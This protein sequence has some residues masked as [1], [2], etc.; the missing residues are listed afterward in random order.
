MKSIVDSIEKVGYYVYNPVKTSQIEGIQFCMLSE[1]EKIKISEVNIIHKEKF[2]NGQPIP[3]GLFDPNMGTVSR[4]YDCS[5]CGLDYVECVGHFGLLD[6]GTYIYKFAYLDRVKTILDLFC[7]NCSRI[8]INEEIINKTMKITVMKDRLRYIKEIFSSSSSS[9]HC[10]H[11]GFLQPVIAVKP[12]GKITYS[13]RL[14][15]SKE[16]SSIKNPLTAE[17]VYEKF[18]RISD[19]DLKILG[20]NPKFSRPENL[21]IRYMLV[22]PPCLRCPLG[23]EKY[24]KPDDLDKLISNVVESASTMR[25][26]RGTTRRIDDIIFDIAQAYNT[27]ILGGAKGGLTDIQGAKSILERIGKKGGII[28][29]NLTGKRVEFAGRTVITGL[30]SL[31]ISEAS[32][33]LRIAMGLTIEERTTKYNIEY[34]QGLVDNGASIYPGA[35]F[36]ERAG[37]MINLKIVKIP[38]ILEI[39]DIVHRHMIEGDPFI[40]NRYPSLHEHS[41]MCFSGKISPISETISINLLITPPFNADFDGDEM[42]VHVAKSVQT[43]IEAHLLANVKKQVMRPATGANYGGFIFDALLGCYRITKYP[44]TLKKELIMNAV[45]QCTVLP[46]FDKIKDMCGTDFISMLLPPISLKKGGVE[47]KLGKITKGGIISKNVMKGDGFNNIPYRIHMDISG[48]LMVDTLYNLQSS[49]DIILMSIG[50]TVSIKDLII[51]DEKTTKR[52]SDILEQAYIEVAEI[53]KKIA[54]NSLIIPQEIIPIN[55]VSALVASHMENGF[56]KIAA[57]IEEKPMDGNRFL[58]MV[59]SGA[60]GK[61]M[62]VICMAFVIGYKSF[63]GNNLKRAYGDRFLP[64]FTRYTLDP[65]NWGFISSSFLDGMDP[66]EFFTFGVAGREGLIDTALGTAEAGYLNRKLNAILGGDYVEYDMTVR[67][68]FGIVIQMLFGGCGFD[69]KYILAYKLDICYKTVTEIKKEYFLSLGEED[70]KKKGEEDNKKKGEEDKKKKGEEDKKKKGE[71]EEEDKKKDKKKKGGKKEKKKKGEKEEEKRTKKEEKKTKKEIL[72][73]EQYKLLSLRDKVCSSYINKRSMKINGGDRIMVYSPFNIKSIVGYCLDNYE[74]LNIKPIPISVERWYWNIMRVVETI[75]KYY[76]NI[77][78]E[79]Q[80]EIYENSVIPLRLYILSELSTKKVI[81]EYKLDEAG[82]RWILDMILFNFQRGLIEPNKNVGCSTSQCISMNSTQMTLNTFHF[83]GIASMSE[84]RTKGI[85]R[86]REILQLTAPKKQKTPSMAIY[87][88]PEYATFRSSAQEVAT[89]IKHLSIID[90]LQSSGIYYEYIPMKKFAIKSDSVWVKEFVKYNV[91]E[92]ATNLSSW[93]IRF[94]FSRIKLY[95]ERL[96]LYEISFAL[97]KAFGRMVYVVSSSDSDETPTIIM[98]FVKDKIPSNKEEFGYV[99]ETLQK[100][101]KKGVH[102]RGISG[103]EESHVPPKPTD[104]LR[105]DIVTQDLVIGEDGKAGVKEWGVGAQ[106][107]NLS[108]ILYESI[109]YI[110]KKKIVSNSAP[111]VYNILGIEASRRILIE[112]IATIFGDDELH[113]HHIELVADNMT[114]LGFLISINRFGILKGNYGELSKIAFEQ[115]VQN[116]KDACFIGK[117]DEMRGLEA[118]IVTGQLIPTGTGTKIGLQYNLD[119]MD[120][121]FT[122]KK[123]G[124]SKDLTKTKKRKVEIDVL[125]L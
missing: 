103:I 19:N 33:P 30:P 73:M 65:K 45:S 76:N 80:C 94:T 88:K 121:Y 6:L 108:K 86:L 50:H 24:K 107:T 98:Y 49:L 20:I 104:I 62:N 90:V 12:K 38:I 100:I 51:D 31:K 27:L 13:H 55:Y 83:A 54:S 85:P 42:N 34:L 115:A 1:Q 110:D 89:A 102:I 61:L 123:K 66:V 9:Y 81:E 91:G 17:M 99:S 43:G 74:Q 32:I 47:I 52:I 70:K 95:S 35:G 79:T 125:D 67:D 16:V 68:A 39:G 92:K 28:R 124:G 106:G 118:N 82:F 69:P 23:G 11:C 105:Y 72:E 46:N 44:I 78:Y 18:S 109:P 56:S 87:L 5:T 119:M 22:P 36:V 63:Q 113:P 117:G 2:T 25:N 101:R 7:F 114:Y 3:L 21:V 4:S 14:A 10:N 59:L 116:I 122:D 29:S 37:T 84:R 53:E 40:L 93:I 75:T 120:K 26:S 57:I 112:Q 96:R 60:K 58:D 8:L 71:K 15:S 97:S 48:S 64:I 77:S 111:E 41:M